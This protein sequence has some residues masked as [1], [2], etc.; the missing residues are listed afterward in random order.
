MPL[1]CLIGENARRTYLHEVAA[2]F[3][4]EGAVLMAAE[5]DLVAEHQR[6][7]IAAARIVPVESRAPVA[8]NTAIHFMV[9]QGP[10][11]LIIE[12]ALAAAVTAINVAVHDCHVL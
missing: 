9:D 1:E 10:Q 5:I 11:V 3:T 2:K 7:E 12:R 4:L 8:L 6:V